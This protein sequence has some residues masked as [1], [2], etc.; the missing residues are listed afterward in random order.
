M[1]NLYCWLA[2]SLALFYCQL[3]SLMSLLACWNL[4]YLKYR[5]LV[6]GWCAR[7]VFTSNPVD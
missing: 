1:Q 4:L 3:A 6:L 5:V 2:S 7:K